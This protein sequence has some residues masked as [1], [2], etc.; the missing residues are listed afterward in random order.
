MLVPTPTTYFLALHRCEAMLFQLAMPY[1]RTFAS[2][3]K[4]RISS[5]ARW[6]SVIQ[7]EEFPCIASLKRFPLTLFFALPLTGP[8]SARKF[9]VLKVQESPINV[10]PHRTP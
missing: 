5:N 10:N 2:S 6:I 4:S 1:D 7:I 3:S 8:S 9:F